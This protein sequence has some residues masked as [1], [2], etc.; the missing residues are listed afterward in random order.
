MFWPMFKANPT[1]EEILAV[2]SRLR[3]RDK[4]E[5]YPLMTVE[6]PEQI[7]KDHF[8]DGS[9]PQVDWAVCLPSGPV[10]ILGAT[11]NFP[12][13]WQVYM[14]A[15]EEYKL[16]IGH[17][18][19]FIKNEMIP[20]LLDLK[21]NYVDCLSISGDKKAAN[22]LKS[23]GAKKEAALREY[24]KNKETYNIYVWRPKYV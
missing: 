1:F 15:T 7:A 10:V 13:N 4:L 18:T 14:F 12:G 17:V 3:P 24:G 5:I 2:S 16:V 23:L 21:A 6:T 20:A 22:W 8:N 19:R 11:E 9:R